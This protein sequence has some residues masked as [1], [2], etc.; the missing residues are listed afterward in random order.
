M[1][2]KTNTLSTAY[3]TAGVALLMMTA[4]WPRLPAQRAVQKTAKTGQQIYTARCASCHGANGEGTKQ[5][6]KPL[7]GSRSVS[8]LSRFIAQSMPP[9]PKKCTGED[10][11]KAAAFLYDAFYSPVAQAKNAPPRVI[12]SR[13][14]VRQFRNSVADILSSFHDPAPPIDAQ[15]GLQAEYFRAKRFNNGERVLQRVDPEVHFDFGQAGPVPDKFEPHQFSIRW[16]GSLLAPETGEYEFVVHSEHAVRLWLNDNDQPLIDAWVKSGND[17]EFHASRFLLAGRSYPLRME[18]TKSTQGVD[19]T[20]K[21]KNKPAAK[22]SI[23]LG[24]R[25]PHQAEAVIPSRCLLPASCQATYIPATPFP[26]DDR[27]IGYERGTSVSKAWDE[28]TTTSALE[29]AGYVTSHL[30]ALSGAAEDA[31]DRDTRLRKFC[32][33]FVE[34][35]FRRPLTPEV[36]G[37]YVDRQFSSAP[38]GVAAVKRVVLLTLKSPRFLYREAG[39]TTSDAYDTASRLSYALWDT[40][41]DQTLLKAAAAGELVTRDQVR[42]QAERLAADPRTAAKVREFFMLWL[43]ADQYPD[44]A[45]SMKLFPGFDSEVAA[46]LRTSL[47]LGLDSVVWSEKSDY[48]ELL[49]SN[50]VFLNGRLAKIYGVDLPPDSPFQ[51]VALDPSERSGLLTHPYLLSSLAYVASSSP[52]HRGVLIARNFLGRV[53]LPPPA[54][55]VPLAAEQHPNMTTRQRVALQTTPAACSG[56][57]SLI[58]PLGFALERFDAIGRLRTA[59][60][61]QPVDSTGG[62]KPRSGQPVKFTGARD[63]SSYLAG[64]DEAH[65]AFVEKMFQH[66]VKQPV[67]A[68]GPDMLPGLMR[69][70]EAQQ[71]SIRKLLIEISTAT[72]LGGQNASGPPARAGGNGV[73]FRNSRREFLRNLGVSAAAMPFIANMPCLASPAQAKRKQRLIVMFSPDGIVPNTFWPDAEGVL[74][75]FKESLKPLEPFRSRTLTLHGVADR[76]RGDGDGHM[77]GIGCL[78]TGIELFP[79][80]VQGGS[81]TPAGWSSGISIDQEIK[82]FLQKDP[83]TRTRFGSL[84]FGVMVPERADTWTRMVYAG[85][86]KPV[87]PENDPYQ[88]FGKLYGRAKDQE[89]LKS[90]LDD[91][92]EDL[93]KVR[94]KVSVQ[95]RQILDEHSTLVREM[96]TEIR[97]AGNNKELAHAVPVL[98]PG[99]RQDNDR[100]P[101]LSK[102]QIDLLVNSFAGDFARVATLQYT[103]SVG[104]ARHRWLGIQ[105]GQHDLSH[106][107]D[108]DTDAQDKLTRINK[109]Y[110]EQLAYLAKRLS[111]TPEPGGH[112]SLLD[113]TLIVW[114]NELGKGNSHTLDNIPFVLVGNG[115]DFKMGRS[116]NYARLPHNRLLLSLAHGMGHQITR[117]GNPDFCGEGPLPNLT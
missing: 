21:Q 4:L 62:Y 12:L 50:Q 64:S 14:T 98:E 39:S 66:L 41:P 17:N 26:P 53:L 44:L 56:C 63:L 38:D 77:R 31:P 71:F 27:S 97:A 89:T 16:E 109:W 25:R 10:A 45:K 117:F 81:D 9:G 112:G 34:R 36:S 73:T 48:R 43:K 116:L 79:G 76:V 30:R 60:N 70:F 28:A 58:N 23:I 3:R 67:R 111:E 94:S 19:D 110:C 37:F 52:I 65:A 24:W 86:N 113:N 47:E 83:A 80:N 95:D 32:R 59:E 8:D 107:P 114:T 57:H 69:T 40:I 2:F 108:S 100:M 85:P 93:A 55:F 5:Y 92:K 6:A 75:E 22:A 49:Q 103:N 84:E 106:M 105:E 74:T 20:E 29:T 13:L 1:L 90:V 54:A 15:R 33:Q 68:Y 99:V 96:E 91:L 102:L 104:Q 51:P 101:V 11:R 7:I 87:A 72:A 78:L 88:M 46:D 61:G 18:F 82:G 35:A 42:Q 115:L